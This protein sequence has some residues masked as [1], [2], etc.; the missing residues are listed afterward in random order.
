MLPLRPMTL[1]S[2]G[3]VSDSISLAP[4]VQHTP[5]LLARARAILGSEDLARDAVQEA[6]LLCWQQPQLPADPCAWLMR[7]VAHRA[8]HHSR[9]RSRA[10]RYEQLRAAE[11]HECDESCNPAISQDRGELAALL[12][13][14]LDE[15]PA[16]FRLAFVQFEL[17]GLSYAQIALSERIPVGT[18]RSRIARARIALRVRLEPQLAPDPW[19]LDCARERYESPPMRRRR[20]R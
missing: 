10:R 6:L 9:T 13:R 16:P 17:E 20:A 2:I 11:Q 14:A 1:P 18:V 12:W 5:R 19:C 8:L 4:F 7:T 3:S 15:L